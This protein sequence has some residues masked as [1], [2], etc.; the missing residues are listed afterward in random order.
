MGAEGM[1]DIS[2]LLLLLLC[3]SLL[4]LV[5]RMKMTT[6]EIRMTMKQMIKPVLA[7]T[8]MP[9]IAAVEREVSPA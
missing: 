2:T 5:R 7:P 1:G 8:V 3:C 4:D 9:A 6:T